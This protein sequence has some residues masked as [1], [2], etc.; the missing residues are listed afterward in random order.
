MDEASVILEQLAEQMGPQREEL[1]RLPRWALVSMSV[2]CARRV[3]P[4][5]VSDWPDAPSDFQEAI[6][7][8]IALTEEA[9]SSA[10]TSDALQEVSKSLA[11]RAAEVANL[12][13][14]FASFTVAFAAV[15]A[16]NVASADGRD[17]A[18]AFA[19]ATSDSCHKSATFAA[20]RFSG[21]R[22]VKT[23]EM[24]KAL[25]RAM[26]HDFEHLAGLARKEDWTDATPV[27]PK[28]LGDLWPGGAPPGFVGKPR[29]R[30]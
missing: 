1:T 15:N 4:L 11:T 30:S 18:V 26:R 20:A 19:M 2:R 13:S 3:Q 12:T 14:R 25:T 16:A 6:E 21:F 10:H 24:T 22:K 5:A 17:N 27:R 28:V 8:C 29:T 9:A 7:T 23:L